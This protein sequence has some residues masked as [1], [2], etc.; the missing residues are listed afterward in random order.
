[1]LGGA[2]YMAGKSAARRSAQEEDQSARI[3]DL[4]AQQ[5]PAQPP[6]PAPPAAGPAGGGDLVSQL[7]QLKDLQDAGALTPEEFE[8]AKQKLLAG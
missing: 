5:A 1:M 4:E 7:K 3:S 6:P 2:G 8:A